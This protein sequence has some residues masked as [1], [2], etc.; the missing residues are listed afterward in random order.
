MEQY[1][2]ALRH[3][4]PIAA[5]YT[6][7]AHLLAQLGQRQEAMALYR[8]ALQ[9]APDDQLAM[10][11]LREAER[12]EQ[13]ALDKAKQAHL[14]QLVTELLH[15]HKEGRKRDLP[16]DGWTSLPL[17]LAFLEPQRKG[18]VAPRAGEEDVLWLSMAH[19]LRA[20]GRVNFVEREILDKVLA[21]LKLSASELVDPQV[22]VRIG[23]ILA[24]RLIATGSFIRA[25]DT[26][27]LTVRLVETETTRIR[28]SGT[29]PIEPSGTFDSVVEQLARA[30]LTQ[31]RQAYPL[32]GRIA[33]LSPQAIIL[34]IGADHGVTPGLT[35]QVFG[36]EEAL[37]R[38]GKVVGYHHTPVGLIEVS[39]VEAQLSQARVLE[40]TTAFQE[41]WKVRERGGE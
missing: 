17:T 31:V 40:Q 16:G 28:A 8:Q 23:Q 33:R 13:L 10:T 25:G 34:D 27:Q 4:Q 11:L 41:G 26:A 7:K 3:S 36:S 29:A 5:V 6:N 21:E 1:D 38:D 24:A 14:D 18:S 35:M 22:A 9:V 15:A 39:G 37:R 2:R 30:L 20:S 12:R 32:Q 19:A